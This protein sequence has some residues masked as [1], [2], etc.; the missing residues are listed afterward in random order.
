MAG[1]DKKAQSRL[2]YFV[3]ASDDI[4]FMRT[5]YYL[6]CLL[7][8]ELKTEEKCICGKELGAGSYL[9]MRTNRQNKESITTFPVGETCSANI[10]KQLGIALPPK[11]WGK[12]P[13]KQ[14]TSFTKYCDFFKSVGWDALNLEIYRALQ[15]IISF[16]GWLPSAQSKTAKVL[17]FI[18]AAPGK[19]SQAFAVFTVNELITKMLPTYS[20]LTEAFEAYL[21]N[22]V[23]LRPDMCFKNCQRI[24]RQHDTISHF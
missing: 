5:Q 1:S 14:L 17:S 2:P 20:T 18:S 22:N 6:R 10:A 8:L 23:T 11:F 3:V 4:E 24:L 15:F 12:S 21:G 19:T 16:S 7:H 9:F 13:S